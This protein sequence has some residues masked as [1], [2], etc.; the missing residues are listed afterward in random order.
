MAIIEEW[1]SAGETYAGIGVQQPQ[2][3]TIEWAAT[4]EDG[5]DLAPPASELQLGFLRD[6]RLRILEPLHVVVG[7]E[8]DGIVS[9]EAGEVNEFGYGGNMTEAVADLQCALAELYFSLEDSQERLGDDLRATWAV[10]Q[11]KIARR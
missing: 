11:R 10:L 3:H 4:F 9:A 8:E 7:E 2:A 6:W 5:V 1:Q